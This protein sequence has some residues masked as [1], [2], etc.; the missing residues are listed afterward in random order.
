MEMLASM[1]WAM[2]A[3]H[4]GWDV[5]ERRGVT[6]GRVAKNE[7]VRWCAKI[8]MGTITFQANALPECVGAK[9]T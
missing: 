6:S 2:V 3:Y 1:V 4:A 7:S 9:K 5:L 8:K